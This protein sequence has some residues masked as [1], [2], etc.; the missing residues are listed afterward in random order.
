LRYVALRGDHGYSSEIE[1]IFQ[2][3]H[4]QEAQDSNLIL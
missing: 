4:T 3:R 2:F 1:D